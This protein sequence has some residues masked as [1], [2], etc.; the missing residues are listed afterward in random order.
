MINMRFYSFLIISLLSFQ[1]LKA[2]DNTPV[3]QLPSIPQRTF[4]IKEYG[5]NGDDKSDNT[6]AIQ[7]AIN[8]ANAAGGGKVIVPAGIY[9]CGPL[10]FYSN[11]ELQL[12]PD[13]IIKMLPI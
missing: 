2:Q 10:Q 3:P 12:Q 1:H 13:A 9:L 8:A 6:T 11:L 4:A 5:A 7:N